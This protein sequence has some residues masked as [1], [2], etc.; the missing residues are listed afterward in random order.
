M[1]AVRLPGYA[2]AVRMLASAWIFDY[3]AALQVPTVV[4][5]GANDRVTPPDQTKRVAA[6]V[7]ASV[8]IGDER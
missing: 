5:C 7:L 8:R 6:S 1:A 4:I 2:Q 3:A